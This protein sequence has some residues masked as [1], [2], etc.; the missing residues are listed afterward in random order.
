MNDLF[1]LNAL[2]THFLSSTT[3]KTPVIQN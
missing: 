2:I 1:I 3:E